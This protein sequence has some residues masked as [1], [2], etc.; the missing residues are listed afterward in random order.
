MKR[1]VQLAMCFSGVRRTTCEQMHGREIAGS[2][3]RSEWNQ[4]SNGNGKGNGKGK[5]KGKS[6]SK[7]KSRS[8]RDDNQKGKGKGK[9]CDGVGRCSLFFFISTSRVANWMG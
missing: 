6:K 7:S 5:D 2:S 3:L 4:E 9:G 1:N 8:L